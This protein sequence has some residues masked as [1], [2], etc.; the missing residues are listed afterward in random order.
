MIPKKSPIFVKVFN[1]LILLLTLTVDNTEGSRPNPGPMTIE[2]N[3]GN[4][5]IISALE[6]GVFPDLQEEI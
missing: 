3:L 4:H 1:F 2:C 5:D 6:T